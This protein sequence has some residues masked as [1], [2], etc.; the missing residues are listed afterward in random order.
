MVRLLR[1]CLVDHLADGIVDI[2]V[3]FRNGR[4][5]DL[6]DSLEDFGVGRSIERPPP[7]QSFVSRYRQGELVRECRGRL[8]LEKLGSQVEQRSLDAGLRLRRGDAR[9]SEIDDLHRI[10]IHHEDVA[11]LDVAVHQAL[12]VRRV[13]SPAGLIDDVHDVLSGEPRAAI[14]NQLVERHPRQQGHDEERFPD[15]LFF[16]LADVVNPNHVGVNHLGH[17]APLLVEQVH[18]GG[19][20]D[21]QNR[22]EGHLTFMSVSSALYTTPIPPLPRTA[23]SSYRS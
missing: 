14:A 2:G 15:A 12:L 5:A 23:R 6:S 1:H 10:V 18:Q 8:H 13:Q 7:R 9:D 21:V 22:L 11:R 3:Q 20:V 17:D 19:V 16:E 4:R